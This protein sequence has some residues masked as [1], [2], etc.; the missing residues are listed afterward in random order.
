MLVVNSKGEVVRMSDADWVKYKRLRGKD[1]PELVPLSFGLY[2][3]EKVFKNDFYAVTAV[4]RRES[5]DGPERVV[6]KEYHTDSWGPIPLGWLGRMLLRRESLYYRELS[7]IPGVPRFLEH[8]GVNG[9]VREH[10]PGLDL[11]DHFEKV[12]ERVHA[13]FFPKLQKTLAAVHNKGIAH[14]DLAKPENVL[15]ASDGSPVLID[16]QIAMMPKRWLLGVGLL[17][18]PVL[19]LCQQM[20]DYHLCK[21]YRRYSPD[22][23]P[24]EIRKKGTRSWGVASFHYHFIRRPYRAVR[25]FFLDR[26]LK[27]KPTA[28]ETVDSSRKA[29]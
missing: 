18:G 7:D 27:L 10:V 9:F 26:F 23:V 14:N 8:F 2:R 17:A 25:H 4:Y 24:D 1:L 22:T 5:G 28:D 6:L 12:G 13:D 29:A 15:V 11:R 21:Q 20:D 19:R 16:F 3:S